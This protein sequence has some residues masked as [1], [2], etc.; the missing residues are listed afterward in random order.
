MKKTRKHKFAM[1]TCIFIFVKTS[2]YLIGVY[3]LQMLDFQ[4]LIRIYKN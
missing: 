2:I 1:K 3:V 4:T